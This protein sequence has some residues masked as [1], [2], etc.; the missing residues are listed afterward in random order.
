MN[1][2]NYTFALFSKLRVLI[3][4]LGFRKN[5]I[6]I[7]DDVILSYPIFL[8]GNVSIGKGTYINSYSHI[9][10]GS[11]S[12]VRIGVYCEISYNVHIWAIS[13]DILYPTG[14]NRK[15]VEK[16]ITIGDYVWIGANV[17][18]KEGVYIGSHSIIGANSVVTKDVLPNT[19]V[20]GV[21]AK[22]I[23]SNIKKQ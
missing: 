11:N 14:P 12:K 5:N 3:L 19:L 21:P 1:A 2:I 20:A 9:K 13:H 8:K 4:N 10:T 16:D 17:F 15:L 18:I 7:E 6:K 23:R 22:I